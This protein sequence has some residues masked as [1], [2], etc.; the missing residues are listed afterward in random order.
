MTT[1]PELLVN[2]LAGRHRARP[3]HRRG[4]GMS[5]VGVEKQPC[6]LCGQPKLGIDVKE[7]RDGSGEWIVVANCRG[8]PAKLDAIAEAV[9]L[10]SAEV[11][12]GVAAVPMLYPICEPET[13]PTPG[14]TR[15]WHRTLL[16]DPS[17]LRY[18]TERRGVSEA[19]IRRFV[20][21]HDGDR[22]TLPVFDWYGR[23]QNGSLPIINLR[24]YKPGGD[25]KM[26][27]LRGSGAQLYTPVRSKPAVIV[28]EGEWDALRAISLGFHAVTQTGG[29][30]CWTDEMTEALG[31]RHV[32]VVYDRDRGG[33]LGEARVRESFERVGR[34]LSLTDVRLPMPF[35][36]KGG[37]DLSDFL[38]D[39]SAHEFKALLR[40]S[41]EAQR[42]P[43]P[44]PRPSQSRSVATATRR[45][46]VSS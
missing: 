37:P 15:V 39:H 40:Q 3:L 41:Y 16:R 8:C 30:L 19:V 26:L 42:R 7:H 46:G 4:P 31:N 20:I 10:S 45:A 44:K 14:R 25:P 2:R 35:K 13:P 11:R 5:K 36:E 33:E 28:A 17:L 24:T 22:F 32:F 34:H 27:S 29:A 23:Y 1:G 18:V 38:A 21:G 12:E 43:R 9:G 6:P